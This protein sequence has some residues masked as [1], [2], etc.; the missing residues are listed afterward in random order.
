MGH[1]GP[2]KGL[3][4]QNNNFYSVSS[5]MNQLALETTNTELIQS[6]PKLTHTNKSKFLV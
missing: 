3:W 5:I 2:L 6:S 4:A 1:K